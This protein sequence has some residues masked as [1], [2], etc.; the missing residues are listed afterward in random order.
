MTRI[1][2][3]NLLLDVLV[4]YTSSVDCIRYSVHQKLK[5]NI[6]PEITDFVDDLGSGET[7]CVCDFLI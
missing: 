1:E 6:K 3:F 4:E 2:G 5:H 7:S